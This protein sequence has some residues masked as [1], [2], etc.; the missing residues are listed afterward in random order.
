MMLQLKPDLD[1]ERDPMA[2]IMDLMKVRL[3]LFL[4]FF[5][6][7]LNIILGDAILFWKL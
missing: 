5:I 1:K 7:L 2:G 4:C 3:P 6:H